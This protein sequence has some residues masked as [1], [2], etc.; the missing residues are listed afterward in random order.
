MAQDYFGDE[1]VEICKQRGLV[2]NKGTWI[3]GCFLAGGVLLYGIGE[4]AEYFGVGMIGV[5]FVTMI[6]THWD[7]ITGIRARDELLEP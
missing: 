3:A 7:N 6:W 5:G 4:E 2:R 1:G